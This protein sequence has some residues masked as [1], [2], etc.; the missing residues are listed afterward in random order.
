MADMT[1]AEL[2]GAFTA[3]RAAL[4]SGNTHDAAE[5]IFRIGAQV[6]LKQAQAF[7]PVVADE[8]VAALALDM[9]DHAK[10]DGRELFKKTVVN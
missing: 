5:I 4:S 6:W 2:N 10:A 1:E 8:F 9:Q 7:G 3:L